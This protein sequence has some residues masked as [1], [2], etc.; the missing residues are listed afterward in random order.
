MVDGPVDVTPLAG[1][2]DIDLVDEP[3]VADSVAAWPSGVCQ[4]WREALDPPVDRD[5]VDLDSALGEELFDVAIG[6]PVTQ[7]P[8]HGEHDDLRREAVSSERGAPER[9]Y[10]LGTR[11]H[12]STLT[13]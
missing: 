8:P 5:V 1:D 12:P 7:I 10:R 2:L 3:P 6:E 9:R 4:E 11:S 13:A